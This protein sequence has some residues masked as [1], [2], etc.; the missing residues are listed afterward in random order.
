MADPAAPAGPPAGASGTDLAERLSRLDTC[1]LSDALDVLHLSGVVTGIV[2]LWEGAR[3]AGPAVTV[4]LVPG[5]PDAAQ[6]RVHLGVRAIE[7]ARPGEVIVVDNGGR[8]QMA[9]WGGLL[10]LA[11]ASK[12][13]AGIVLDGACRDVDE[14]RELGFPVFARCA[15][16]RTARRRVYEQSTGQPVSIGGAAVSQGDFVV[17][18]G[19]GL[20]VI[21]RS[22]ATE[23]VVQAERISVAE[24]E[25]AARL[26]AG[27]AAAAVLGHGYESMI[28]DPRQGA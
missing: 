25:M 18:D 1:A 28:S 26:K 14:A 3:L 6:A 19:S 10:C 13:V 11:A 16:P 24:H 2:P 17:A 12:G 20:V 23:V 7:Q 21:P 15:V 27:E 9:G 8:T 22:R 5:V 4:S